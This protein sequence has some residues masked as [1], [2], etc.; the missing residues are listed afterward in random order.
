MESEQDHLPVSQSAAERLDEYIAQF[1]HLADRILRQFMVSL[2]ERGVVSIDQIY[3]EARILA[4]EGPSGISENQNVVEAPRGGSSERETVNELTRKY[5][6]SFFSRHQIDSIINLALKREEADKLRAIVSLNSV[7]FRL[8]SDT[9]RRFCALPEGE[10]QLAPDEAIGIRVGLIRHFISDQ[11]EFIAIAKQ[12]LRIRDF[13]HIVNRII[14]AESGMGRIGGKAAGMFLASTIISNRRVPST[15]EPALPKEF[16]ST[17]GRSADG[18]GGVAIPESYFL[19]SDV[20]EDFIAFNGYGEYQNQKYKTPEEIRKEYRIIRGAFRNGEFPA[21]IVD[22]LRGILQKIGTHPVIV[23]SSSLLEDRFGTAFSG[24]YASI[25]V[26]N[27]GS[28][29]RRLKELLGAIAEVYASALG[30][31]PLLYRREHDLIDYQEDMAVLIQ[32]V[33]GRRFGPYFAPMFAGVAFSRNEYRWSPRIK[34][35]EGLMRIVMGLGTRAVDRVGSEFPR[36]VALGMP[37]LRHESTMPEVVRHSQ[38]TIDVINLEKNKMES[39]TIEQLWGH[40]RDLQMLDRV[41]SIRKDGMLVPPTGTYIDCDPSDLFV[42]FDKLMSEGQFPNQMRN[43]LRKLEEA[44]GVP[45]DVEFAHD[46]EQ[47]YLLQCRTQS[48]VEEAERVQIPTDI[49]EERV[50]FTANKFIRTGLVENI[51]YVINIDP[52]DYDA[53]PTKEGRTAVAR[54]VGRLNEVLSGRRF[55]LIGPGRWGSNDMRLGVPVT[56]A[57][58]NKSKM[59]IEVARERDGYV[60]EVSFGTHFFQDLVEARIAY[61]PL[62]PDD[63]RNRFNETFLQESPN[64]LARLLPE[65]ADMTGVVRVIDVAAVSGGRTLRVVM[66]GETDRATAYLAE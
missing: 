14:G 1:P 45:V 35:E 36:M 6:V 9:L 46:G 8:I 41:F 58:I 59:L 31:D 7:S 39:I 57:D 49:P 44:Y 43:I 29:E 10:M 33:I 48:Q 55:I 64:S 38:R 4:G 27:Q 50:V 22:R 24:K 51:E 2:H 47:L 25:F 52:R 53:L 40:A 30:P 34:K 18:E 19:R 66:D 20:I 37:T 54:V 11:L 16:V 60:P 28:P 61:L 26:A 17:G 21:G 5:A 23:R 32:K 15:Q 62:Y 42:T 65:A 63:R 12:Y 13:E 3:D 56:Y